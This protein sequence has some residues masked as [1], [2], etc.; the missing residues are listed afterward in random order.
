MLRCRFAQSFLGLAGLNLT[1]AASGMQV[2]SRTIVLQT[3]PVADFQYHNGEEFAGLRSSKF[4]N[5][6][7]QKYGE[8]LSACIV[9]LNDENSDS[10]E[11]EWERVRFEVLLEESSP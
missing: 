10:W 11:W 8:K 6:H 4:L 9:E 1:S 3:S 2:K 5:E 7:P